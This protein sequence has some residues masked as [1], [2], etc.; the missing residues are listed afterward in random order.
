M[1]VGVRLGVAGCDLSPVRVGRLQPLTGVAPR[2]A[3]D[4]AQLEQFLSDLR[5]PLTANQA[6]IEL[7]LTETLP[8]AAHMALRA[9]HNHSAYVSQLCAEFAELGRLEQDLVHAARA[10]A[11]VLEWLDEVI[12]AHRAQVG[13]DC[14]E[15]RWEFRSLLPDRV[16]LDAA[17][18]CRAVTAVLQVASVRAP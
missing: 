18:L 12:A 14:G 3:P 5:L 6:M 2:A 15:T 13:E 9:A 1:K 11:A 8:E 4:R 16:A 10:D 7:V 17:L